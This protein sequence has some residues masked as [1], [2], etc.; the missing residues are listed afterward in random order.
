MNSGLRFRIQEGDIMR[1]SEIL[2]ILALMFISSSAH[3]TLATCPACSGEQPDWTRSATSFLEGEPIQDTPSTLSG[4]QQARLLN[5]QIDARKKASIDSNTAKNIA[6]TPEHNS[7][8]ISDIHLND[9]SA[10]PNPAKFNDAVKIVAVF[11]NI[12][13][14]LATRDGPSSATDLTNLTV[15]ADIKNSAG[16]DV[17]RV[18]LNQS[19]E[20]E[21]SG[22]WN[23]NAGSDTYNATIEIAGPDGSKAFNDALQIIVKAKG[24]ENTTGNINVIKS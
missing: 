21:Y 24:S 5:A 18:N 10:V 14:N 20:N 16:S 15:Y 3:A 11:E 22:I 2:L 1:N 6:A 4:P 13:R 7:T 9:L 17:G 23:A 19:S 12:S 8:P